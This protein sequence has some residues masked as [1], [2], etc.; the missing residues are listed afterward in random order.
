MRPGRCLGVVLHR[1]R[2]PVQAPQ[3]LDDAVVEVD[4]AHLDPSV[5]RLRLAVGGCVDREAVVVAGDGYPSGPPVLHRLVD[6]A[7]A[8]LQLV[9]AEAERPAQDLVAETDAED[10]L[11]RVERSAH[12]VDRIVGGRRV[13]GSVGEEHAVRINGEQVG[14][15]RGCGQDVHLAAEQ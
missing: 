2:R 4:V 10:R 14:C 6:A 15:R 1:E 7:V 9:S 13:T 12:R 8:E 5:L 3:T 11:S